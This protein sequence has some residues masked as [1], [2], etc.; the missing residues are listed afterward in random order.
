MSNN[1]AGAG[2]IFNLF[3]HL[4]DEEK[5]RLRA[6][7]HVATTFD[8][9]GLCQLAAPDDSQAVVQQYASLAV[10]VVSAAAALATLGQ[11]VEMMNGANFAEMF[12]HSPFAGI[13]ELAGQSRAVNP[14]AVEMQRLADIQ[15]ERIQ[16]LDT[17]A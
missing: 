5:E 10:G 3:E 2:A 11:L 9:S 16:E 14:F 12:K 7:L 4:T 15:R 8:F 13:Y 6:R 17:I 1:T